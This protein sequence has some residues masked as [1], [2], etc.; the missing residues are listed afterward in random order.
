[1]DALAEPK[2]ATPAKTR[3][4]APFVALGLTL[5]LFTFIGVRYKQ[6]SEQRAEIAA[7]ALA[8]VTT[9][10][11]PATA[12]E[13]SVTR[14]AVEMWQPRVAIM[15]TLTPIRESNL[16]FKVSGRLATVEASTG[17]LVKTGQRLASLD[18][19]DAAA[20]VNAGSALV[21]ASEVELAIARDTE[22]RSRALKSQG[23]T[24]DAQHRGD[25]QRV[26]LAQARLEQAKAQLSAAVTAQNNNRLV[27]PFGGRITLGPS[28]PGATVST[29]QTLFRLEDTSALRLLATL[30]VDDASLVSVGATV[31]VD[32]GKA[33][34]RVTAVLPSVD[35]Q[36]RRVPM[37]AEI[38]NTGPAPL[39]GGVLVRATVVA[40][41]TPV[42]VVKLPAEAL[43]PG[44][45]DE[46]VLVQGD[47]AKVVRA[48]FARDESGSL[49]VREGVTETDVVVIGPSASTRTGDVL[50]VRTPAAK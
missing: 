25:A 9:A 6:A 2:V 14:G 11:E 19:A 7:K 23:A 21:H 3:R 17:H 36:T 29:G 10:V 28:A 50:T 45:Q 44:S 31:E 27:A 35:A 30:S 26:Q 32:G 4:I 8:A 1:M 20:Q 48:T 13:V 47:K 38:D 18:S 42:R 33:Q 5:L 34:G 46:F 24:T 41:Q 22:E 16:S 39:L 49:L 43:R 12:R 15:G 40:G 37:L